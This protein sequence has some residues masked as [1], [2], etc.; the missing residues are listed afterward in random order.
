MKK[1][2]VEVDYETMMNKVK[3]KSGDIDFNLGNYKLNSLV[4]KMICKDSNQRYS[5]DI[6]FKETEESFPFDE[7]KKS[8]E[9]NLIASLKFRKM[10]ATEEEY[11]RDHEIIANEYYKLFSFE[12]W[13]KKCEEILQHHDHSK[14]DVSKAEILT[15]IGDGLLEINDVMRAKDYFVR[16]S[17]IYNELGHKYRANC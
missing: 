17:V 14:N 11:L 3:N 9:S 15:K 4:N 6:I 10:K 7:Y 8:N 13:L 5:S 12:N 16:A 2:E 1:L